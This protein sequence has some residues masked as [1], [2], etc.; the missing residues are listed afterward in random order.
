[1]N[2][3]KKLENAAKAFQQETIDTG[4]AKP[5]ITLLIICT[6]GFTQAV[7]K[8]IAGRKD[9]YMSDHDGINQIFA[10]YGGNYQIPLFK[11]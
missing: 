3:I 2:Q 4:R 9:F 11:T 6:G 7:K 5:D 10:A 1:M 8:H